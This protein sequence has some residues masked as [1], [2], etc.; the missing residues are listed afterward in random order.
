MW[1]KT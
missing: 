1:G